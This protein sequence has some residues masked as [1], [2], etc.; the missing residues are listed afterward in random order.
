MIIIIVILHDT[1]FV[2]CMR[3]V[4]LYLLFLVHA[5]G[6]NYPIF[7]T[8]ER[9]VYDVLPNSTVKMPSCWIFPLKAVYVRTPAGLIGVSNFSEATFRDA[10][11]RFGRVKKVVQRYIIQTLKEG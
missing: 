11:G 5:T 4:W 8:P 3:Y 2:R 9:F 10:D 1:Q 7:T 6:C